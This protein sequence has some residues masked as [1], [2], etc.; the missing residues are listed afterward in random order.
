MVTTKVSFNT[1]YKLWLGLCPFGK[2]LD[3]PKLV[4]IWRGS[5]FKT[6]QLIYIN[7]IPACRTTVKPSTFVLTSDDKMPTLRKIKRAALPTHKPTHNAA[8]LI[9]SKRTAII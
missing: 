7:V 8:H 9:L 6:P 3:Y 1:V 4:Y 5:C 2:S